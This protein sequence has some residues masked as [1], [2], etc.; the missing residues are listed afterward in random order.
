MKPYKYYKNTLFRS[1]VITE[2]VETVSGYSK[3]QSTM[4]LKE[5]ILYVVEFVDI[6]NTMNSG[7]GQLEEGRKA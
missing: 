6:G 7:S 4:K 1:S 5:Q 2:N 3:L